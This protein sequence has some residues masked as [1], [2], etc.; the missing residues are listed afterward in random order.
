MYKLVK[1]YRNDH[2]LRQRFNELAKK[3]FGID[4]ED[5]YQN[6]YWNEKYNPYSIVEDGR[7]IANVSV[8]ITQM[9]LDGEQ[10]CLIQL[11]TVMTEDCYRNQG[12]IRKIMEAIDED[13]EGK[14]DG[15]YLF[16]NESVLD[17]YPKFNFKKALE[18][19]YSKK[20]SIK[21]D[22]TMMPIVMNNKKAWSR[23]EQVMD[24]HITHSRFSAVD[25]NELVMFYVTKYMQENVY[26]DEKLDTYVIAEINGD[27]IL[28]YNIFSAFE[29]SMD[30]I[31][32][33]F[34]KE[35]N[36]VR[37][38][39]IPQNAEGYTITEVREQDTTLFLKGIDVKTFE[40]AQVMFPTLVHA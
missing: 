3:T 5:W 20:V 27:E 7:V 10:K 28:I 31:I 22:R 29:I 1:N 40:K 6:G 14:I 17:F 33:A 19:E 21:K 37:L 15:I 9:M 8:N 24:K 26:Y 38:G 39:F 11:G 2:N 36:K 35:I 16:A 32:E 23:L 12:L 4:F 30:T 25:S 13:Y 18:Y 34:G